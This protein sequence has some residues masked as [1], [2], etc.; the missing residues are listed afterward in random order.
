MVAVSQIGESALDAVD[1]VD[2][3]LEN[4][5]GDVQDFFQVGFGDGPL[6]EKA[7]ALLQVLSEI[8]RAVPADLDIFGLDFIERVAGF[9]RW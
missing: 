8:Q 2:R 6:R 1:Q 4:P 3:L 5:K 7:E 9:R